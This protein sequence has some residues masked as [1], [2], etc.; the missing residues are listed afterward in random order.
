MGAYIM[1]LLAHYQ[2]G[3]TGLPNDDKKLARIASVTAKVWD[4]IKEPV[5]EKF[6]EKTVFLSKK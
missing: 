1:L 5:L 4:R 2:I 3:E 6:D